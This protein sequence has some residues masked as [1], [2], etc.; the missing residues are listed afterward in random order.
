MDLS[1]ECSARS[2]RAARSAE[3]EARRVPVKMVFPLVFCLM[4]SLFIFIIGPI[5]VNFYTYV[6]RP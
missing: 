1:S 2:E 4:P 3:E 6:S 5:A